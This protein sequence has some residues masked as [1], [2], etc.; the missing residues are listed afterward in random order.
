M[1]RVETLVEK[2]LIYLFVV[3]GIVAGV[4]WLSAFY[5]V[6][7]WLMYG[8]HHWIMPAVDDYVTLLFSVAWCLG[9]LFGIPYL[10]IYQFWVHACH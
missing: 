9:W 3:L 1:G 4:L 7:E 6:L 2:P 8:L 10:L 5:R